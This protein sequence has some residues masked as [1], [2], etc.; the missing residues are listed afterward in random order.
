MKLIQES[1]SLVELNMMA[2]KMYGNLVKAVVDIQKEV[3]V[4][5]SAFH[6]DQEEFLTENDSQQTNLWGINLHPDKFGQD[7]W[8]EFDSM[9]NLRPADNNRTRGVEDPQ[10]Q[11]KIR[12]IVAKLVK[13]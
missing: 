9:I 7:G 1:I 13:P 11:K 6:S 5:D 2:Q 10:I 12:D 8:I 3:M 4:V